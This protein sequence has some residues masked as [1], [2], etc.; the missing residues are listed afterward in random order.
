MGLA[1]IIKNLIFEFEVQS[2]IDQ[3]KYERALGL[4]E[5]YRS[6]FDRET[7]QLNL[8]TRLQL[9]FVLTRLWFV[10]G[11]YSK[12][13][14]KINAILNQPSSV[15]HQPLYGMCR[16]MN[17]Q[18]NAMLENTEYLV[19]AVR[20]VERKLSAGARF[21]SV[22]KLILSFLKHWLKLKPVKDLQRQLDELRQN[23]FERQLMKELDLE[24]WTNL[25]RVPKGLA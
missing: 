2:F 20:S 23:P 25:L 17:L 24:E 10:T 21:F 3:K 1:L 14:K 8:Q 4:V 15:I 13:L 16:L 19:H 9:Q 6:D 7:G 11:N 12:S 18:I 5:E 22:E